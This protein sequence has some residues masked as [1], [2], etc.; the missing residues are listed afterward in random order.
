MVQMT[1]AVSVVAGVLL[2]VATLQA[3]SI[4]NR[5]EREHT[6]TIMEGEAKA[7]YVLKP[8]RTLSDVCLKGCII[9]VNDGENNEYRLSGGDAVSIED[10]TVFY[11]APDASMRPASPPGPGKRP[12]RNG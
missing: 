7:D 12:P 6:V 4:T 3:A 5:E 10:G 9:R 2:S 11:D 1:R 8:S